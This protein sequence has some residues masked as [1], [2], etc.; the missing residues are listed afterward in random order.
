MSDVI[1]ITMREAGDSRVT[2]RMSLHAIE[3]Y[4]ERVRPALGV[5]AAAAECRPIAQLADLQTTRRN[6]SH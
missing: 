4:Y 1:L 2:V 5:S 3:R 6:G